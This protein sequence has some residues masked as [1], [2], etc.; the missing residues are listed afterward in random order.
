MFLARQPGEVAAAVRT[1]VAVTGVITQPAAG[2]VIPSL[3]T[4]QL[5]FRYLPGQSPTLHNLSWHAHL[6]YNKFALQS[7]VCLCEESAFG[8]HDALR[9]YPCHCSSSSSCIPPFCI[10]SDRSPGHG[11][12]RQS[13][14]QL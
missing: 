4:A 9:S 14:S 1:T 11:C 2:N 13:P 5:N 6:L 12:L 3:A 10:S 8:H 7:L